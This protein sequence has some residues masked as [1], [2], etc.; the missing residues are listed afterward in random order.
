MAVTDDEGT[1]YSYI[2]DDTKGE[3]IGNYYFVSYNDVVS[4]DAN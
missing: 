3:K 2:Q 4:A 1:K